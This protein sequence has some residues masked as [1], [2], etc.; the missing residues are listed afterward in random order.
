MRSVK[1]LGNVIHEA[2]RQADLHGKTAHGL[3]KARLSLIAEAGG[4]AH[5]IMAWGGHKSLAEAQH[6][7]TSAALRGLVIGAE[8]E[9][10]AVNV[11]G[12]AVNAQN[13]I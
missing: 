4:S 11:P 8:Q 13:N 2:A 12:K 6:Y 3:R 10:N 5:A 7:T 1:G 9:Q